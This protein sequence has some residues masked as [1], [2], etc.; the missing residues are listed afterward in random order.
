MKKIFITFITLVLAISLVACSSNDEVTS[1]DKEEL[2]V[3]MELAYP[4]F[5]MT[6]TDG[7]PTGVSVDIANALGE[8]LGRPVK[9]E[10]MSYSGLIPSLTTKKI[11]IILSSMTI[12]EERKETIDFSDPYSKS[13]L[14]LLVNKDSSVQNAE[15]LNAE[16]IKIAVKKGTTGHIYATEHFPKAEIMVYEKESACVLDVVQGKADAF[17]YDQ[18]TIY[19]NWQNYPD[20]TRA[21]LEPFQEDFEYWGIAMRQG[22]DEL[23]SEINQFLK[24]YKEKGE[25]EKLAEKYFTEMKKNFDDMG[26]PFFF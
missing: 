3:G 17:I 14:S 6:D 1:N 26:I 22:E 20:S 23:K 7:N 25:F 19:K 4:P 10:N 21:V 24:E 15:D 2:I 9:I 5:E 16:G 18:M 12:T 13:Y 11:D 8:Y